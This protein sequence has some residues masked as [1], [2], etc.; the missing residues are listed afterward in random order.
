MS[1]AAST[2]QFIINVYA[3]V[4]YNAQIRFGGIH[5]IKSSRGALGL[6]TTFPI[7]LSVYDLIQA[8]EPDALAWLKYTAVR[9]CSGHNSHVV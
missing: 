3:V 8:G 7:V 1:Q 4:A 9:V 5:Y 2:V 6:V